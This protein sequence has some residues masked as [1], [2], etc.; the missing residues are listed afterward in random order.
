MKLKTWH[1]ITNQGEFLRKET[2]SEEPLE[3]VVTIH[4]AFFKK[5][6][7]KQRFVLRILIWWAIKNYFKSFK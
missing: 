1:K 2:I 3:E 4:A 7:R 6:A 5:P